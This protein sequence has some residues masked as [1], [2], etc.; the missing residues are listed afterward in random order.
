MDLKKRINIHNFEVMVKKK[1]KSVIKG[2]W[3]D[4]IKASV[5]GNPKAKKKKKE[6][7]PRDFKNQQATDE[8]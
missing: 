3:E 4:V 2:N 6:T 1:G 5:K 8:K 7:K